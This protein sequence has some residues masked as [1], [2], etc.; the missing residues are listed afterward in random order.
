MPTRSCLAVR[1]ACISLQYFGSLE[2]IILDFSLTI[3]GGYTFGN[4]I[5]LLIRHSLGRDAERGDYSSKAVF[6]YASFQRQR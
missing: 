1:R 6:I 2:D 3:I 5:D 4:L